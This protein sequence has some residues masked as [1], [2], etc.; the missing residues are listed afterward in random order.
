MSEEFD[1]LAGL[2]HVANELGLGL[3]VGFLRAR[4]GKLGVEVAELLHRERGV[5]R[6]DQKVRL[7]AERLDLGFGVG[8]LLAQRLDLAGQ[9]LAGAAR[10]ILLGLL[11]A[12]SR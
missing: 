12:L 11:Q 10:L 9:P 5:V 8:D 4:G 1:R 7:G 2:E 6:A 3:G